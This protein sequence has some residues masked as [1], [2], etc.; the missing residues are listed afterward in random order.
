MSIQHFAPGDII[1]ISPFGANFDTAT[2]AT[3][4]R[5]SHL[6]VFRFA[7]KAGKLTPEHTAAG[8]IIIQCL[9][10]TVELTTGNR[11]QIL[12]ANTLTYLK[13]GEPHAVKA[14]TDSTLLITILL[15]RE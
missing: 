1:D 10:G 12:T 7:L 3:L 4:I 5:E 9:E 13:D 11:S 15:K 6:E 14:V 8:A 2:S